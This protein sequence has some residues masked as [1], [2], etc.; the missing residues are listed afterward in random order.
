E[1]GLV[2]PL[3][4]IVLLARDAVVRVELAAG[5]ARSIR[6]EER[7]EAVRRAE[8]DDGLRAEPDRERVQEAGGRLADREQEVVA[9]GCELLARQRRRCGRFV[10]DALPVD[11]ENTVE[12]LVHCCTTLRGIRSCRLTLRR[13]RAGPRPRVLA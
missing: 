10:R 13:G 12:C 7:R 1:A 2:D 4:G 3:A 9:A 11:P 8:L 5:R 6:K